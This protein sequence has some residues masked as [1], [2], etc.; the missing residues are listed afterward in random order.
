MWI[1][2]E[3]RSEFL[4]HR[5]MIGGWE[6]DSPKGRWSQLDDSL[7]VATVELYHRNLG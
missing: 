1:V 6:N 4:S 7:N 2:P 3:Q 5:R